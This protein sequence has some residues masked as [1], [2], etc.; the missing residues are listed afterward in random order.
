MKI[1]L[2]LLGCCLA[3]PPLHGQKKIDVREGEEILS[4]LPE[5][6][7]PKTGKK[8]KEAK[9]SNDKVKDPK[10]FI[11][12]IIHRDYGDYGEMIRVEV[13]NESPSLPNINELL[14]SPLAKDPLKY[15]VTVIDGFNAVVQTLYRED[16]QVDYELLMPLSSSLLSVKSMGYSRDELLDFVNTIPVSQIAKKLSK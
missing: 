2:L 11:G 8:Q 14:L 13:I 5:A 9:K 16:G 15:L 1:I 7:I 4:L 10:G 12:V 3:I 6:A